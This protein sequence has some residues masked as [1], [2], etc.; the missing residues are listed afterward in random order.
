M[1]IAIQKNKVIEL[2]DKLDDFTK[3]FDQDLLIKI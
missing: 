1:L 2:Q 3:I